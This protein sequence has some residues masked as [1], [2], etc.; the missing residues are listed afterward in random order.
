VLSAV[1]L[2][3]AVEHHGARRHVD[4]HGEGL[5][6]EE[7]PQQP[8]GEAHLHQLLDQR[9]QACVVQ[10]DARPEKLAD[11]LQLG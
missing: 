6:G 9:E 10:P 8:A 3:Q 4:A 1:V 5:G 2:A 7:H 11:A